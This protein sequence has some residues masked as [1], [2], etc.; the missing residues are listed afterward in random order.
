VGTAALGCPGERSSP[1]CFATSLCHPERLRIELARQAGVE[2]PGACI[3]GALARERPQEGV[4]LN[5]FSREAS[6]AHHSSP[7]LSAAK[8]QGTFVPL[9]MN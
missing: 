7:L 8:E 4:M 6:R 3:V 2:G 5:G 1:E 9:H